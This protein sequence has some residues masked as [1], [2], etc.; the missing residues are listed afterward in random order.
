MLT[1]LLALGIL[2][3]GAVSAHADPTGTTQNVDVNCGSQTF[4]V[5][6]KTA[7][8]GGASAFDVQAPNG[9][10]YALLSVAGH[11]TSGALS[12]D[13]SHVYGSRNGYANVYTGCTGSFTTT[14]PKSGMVFT[15]NFT[16]DIATK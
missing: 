13:F 16:V 11:V 10:A 4:Q 5:L 3:G 14:D 6:I 7:H 1:A 8:G 12:F 15:N 9:R 2:A